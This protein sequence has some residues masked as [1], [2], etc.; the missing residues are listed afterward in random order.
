MDAIVL[1]RDDHKTAE[2]LFERFEK[3]SDDDTAERRRIADE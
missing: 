2:K 3:T 1:L